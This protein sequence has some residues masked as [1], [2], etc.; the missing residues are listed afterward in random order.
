MVSTTKNVQEVGRKY[1]TEWSTQVNPVLSVPFIWRKGYLA[2]QKK[3]QKYIL[4]NQ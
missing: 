2:K 3:N 1:E 4:G